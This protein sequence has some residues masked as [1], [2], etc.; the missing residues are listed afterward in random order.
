MPTIFRYLL[1]IAVRKVLRCDIFL[2][3]INYLVLFSYSGIAQFV[4]NFAE[5]GAP[6]YAP[7]VQKGET[8][9]GLFSVSISHVLFIMSFATSPSLLLLNAVTNSC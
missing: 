7:P 9:V 1:T 3:L 8:P 4:N 6:E 5:P 2:V